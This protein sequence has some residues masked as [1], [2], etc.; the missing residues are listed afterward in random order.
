MRFAEKIKEAR[1]AKN[2]TQAELASEAGISL[3]TITNYENGS[4]YPKKR[5]IYGKLASIL[6]VEVNYLL[7]EDEE[8]ITEAS[9]RYGIKGE[10]DAKAVLTQAA[11][12]FAG[13]E[14]SDEDKLAFM[15][16]IQQLYLESKDIA[17]KKFTPKKYRKEKN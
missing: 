5:E 14:L 3:R 6:G 4:R 12:A 9:E 11:A 2:M 16:E 8:F 10:Q 13:G 1:Q 17:A 15:T 7:T